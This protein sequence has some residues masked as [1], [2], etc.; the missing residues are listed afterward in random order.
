LKPLSSSGLYSAIMSVFGHQDDLTAHRSNGASESDLPG[1]NHLAGARV[2]LAEDNE[3]NQKF[4]VALLNM[5]GLQVDVVP[6][7]KAA[8]KQLKRSMNRNRTIYDAVLM[9][10]EMPVMDGYTA[11][12]IIRADPCFKTLPIIAMTAH[13]LKGIEDQCIEA[14]M[15]DYVSKPI[16]DR[17]LCVMLARHIRPRSRQGAAQPATQKSPVYDVWQ[18]MPE[19]I[20]EINL[21]QALSLIRGNTG[22]LRNIM[23]SFLENFGDAEEKLSRYLDQGDLEQAQRLIHT[24]K[25]TAG[26]LGAEALFAAAGD[27]EQH[28]KSDTGHGLRPAMDAFLK[29]HQ[30]VIVALKGLNFDQSCD[31]RR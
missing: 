15:S 4:A 11:T 7:G 21:H 5:L 16:D 1:L 13:A 18:G 27:L 9:D 19:Q 17:Q 24:I 31:R 22:L 14:G 3:I 30:R 23:H 8:F 6:N 29:R 2:L 26:N 10:I 20:P 28:L 12:R 25:G